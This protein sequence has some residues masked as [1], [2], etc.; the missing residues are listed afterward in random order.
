MSNFYYRY[1]TNISN[2]FPNGMNR[3]KDPYVKGKCENEDESD[4]YRQRKKENENN[5]FLFSRLFDQSTR[6]RK[7]TLKFIVQLI[8]IVS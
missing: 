3:N 2:F 1:I 6:K 4:E 8:Y 7:K 5:F